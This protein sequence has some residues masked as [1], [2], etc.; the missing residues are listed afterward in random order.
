MVQVGRLE[1]CS[2]LF[3]DAVTSLLASPDTVV[4]SRLL[5]LSLKTPR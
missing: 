1:L 4:S 3:A 5:A 2:Q